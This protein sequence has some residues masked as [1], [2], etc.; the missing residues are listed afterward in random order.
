MK[1]ICIA[2]LSAAI[3][4]RNFGQVVINEVAVAASDRNLQWNASGAPQLGSGIPWHA[5]N[6]NATPWAGGNLPAGWGTTV[7]TNLQSA[8]QNK[9]PSLYLR[10]TFTVT[11]TQAALATPLVL[12]VEAD[13]GFVAYINGV[14]VA[15]ANCGPAKHFMYV[16]QVAYNAMTTS[17]LLE[18]P[19]L[20]ANTLLVS[21]TNVLSIQAH[22]SNIGSNFRLNAGLRLI[23]STQTVTLTKALYDFSNANGARR[24]HTNSNGTV[25]NVTT[26]SPP[27]GGWLAT[28]ANPTSD[29]TWASLQ[30][31]SA[32][33]QGAGVGGSGGMRYAIMQSGTNRAA[34]I[35]APPVSM[36]GAWGLGEVNAPALAGTAVKFRY[37]TTGDVQFALRIDP[38]LDLA[39]SSVDGLPVIGLPLGGVADYEWASASGGFYGVSVNAAGTPTT[40]LGGSINIGTYGFTVG[41]GVR[42]GQVILK[43]DSTAGAGPGASTGTLSWLFTTW[44]A[45]VDTLGFSVKSLAVPEWVAG[46][47][48]TTN[49]QRTRLSFRWKMPV[50][51]TQSFYLKTNGVGT[52]ADRANLG[53]FTGT[54]GW[55]TFSASLSDIPNSAS[56][57]TKSSR[58]RFRYT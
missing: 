47:I 3:T 39:A 50:G 5:L 28:V 53:T 54:G 58:P 21:G 34:A 9:T 38:A 12:Q 14:E 56:L 48:T 11:P 29:N 10:K 20:A 55:E 40:L 25:T 44:P 27:A 23:T 4:S 52:A 41:P 33:E 43:E 46:A 45:V 8:M 22:N 57:R 13:D 24:T 51:R 31:V 18:Y 16:S 26:G 36:S 6:F 37:R 17:G 30:I 42:S 7:N 49:F 35:H 32:E 1:R 2:L 19:L 15:R